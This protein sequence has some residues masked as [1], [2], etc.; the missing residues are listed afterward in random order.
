MLGHTTTTSTQLPDSTTFLTHHQQ[1]QQQQQHVPVAAPAE[2][3]LVPAEHHHTTAAPNVIGD[4]DLQITVDTAIDSFP[5]LF[6]NVNDD[7]APGTTASPFTSITTLT[8]STAHSELPVTTE[9]EELPPLLPLSVSTPVTLLSRKDNTETT[10]ASLE[11][12]AEE[13]LQLELRS[14]PLR[15]T[16]SELVSSTSQGFP[17]DS[18]QQQQQQQIIQLNQ[19]L[20]EQQQP[21]LTQLPVQQQEPIFQ[22]PATVQ[23]QITTLCN[24][25][26][27]NLNQT[28]AAAASAPSSTPL[29]FLNSAAQTVSINSSDIYTLT[30]TDGSVVQLRV[31]PD[32][33]AAAAA[34]AAT[35][36][37]AAQTVIEQQPQQQQQQNLTLLSNSWPPESQAATSVVTLS[38]RLTTAT[39]TSSNLTE[40]ALLR[41]TSSSP[42]SVAAEVT[43]P[44]S[45]PHT[46]LSISDSAT[47][48]LPSSP[49]AAGILCDD[50]DAQL[51][52]PVASPHEVQ[53]NHRS[54]QQQQQQLSPM[55]PAAQ[56]TTIQHHRSSD[57]FSCS[58]D[59][60][61]SCFEGED[62]CFDN[63]TFLNMFTSID[64]VTIEALKAQLTTLPEG[65]TDLGQLLVAAKIDLTLDDIVVPP[66][67]QVKRIMEQKELTD[68]QTQLCIKIRRRKKNTVRASP[69]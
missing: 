60:A 13:D 59:G 37:T 29:V 20:P 68:W 23:Q 6:L 19:Q 18:I 47:I 3:L 36:G 66:L 15:K 43:L 26:L 50:D 63:E 49:S 51:L 24:S 28:T 64:N 1:Q 5:D 45:N 67:T 53:P 65:N 10:A 39:T 32:Q 69:E 11:G 21:G 16:G 42:A 12:P 7:V 61:A 27:D 31:Q 40:S 35:A 57:S 4:G 55:L 38:P 8:Q 62:D 33:T 46:P 2:S 48:S 44:F 25:T 58:S 22:Q 9:E 41:S 17:S 52:S 56:P 34:A 14:T 30:L 54:P